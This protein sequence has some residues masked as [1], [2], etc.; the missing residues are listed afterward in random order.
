LA[1]HEVG[2]GWRAKNG[3]ERAVFTLDVGGE[4]EELAVFVDGHADRAAELILVVNVGGFAESV[5][6]GQTAAAI[7]FV[8][9]TVN[10]VGA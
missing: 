7:I 5:V 3:V 8:G 4:E 6:R 9:F 10:L 2:G 1:S